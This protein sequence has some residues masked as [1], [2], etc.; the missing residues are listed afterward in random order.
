[1]LADSWRND[2]SRLCM[3]GTWRHLRKGADD[4]LLAGV[5]EQ[6]VTC[7]LRRFSD[8]FETRKRSHAYDGVSEVGLPSTELKDENLANR[9]RP[10]APLGTGVTARQPQRAA[11]RRGGREV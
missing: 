1:M 6:R 11:G 10:S 2:G 4:S 8:F 7:R 9:F 3:E 5:R